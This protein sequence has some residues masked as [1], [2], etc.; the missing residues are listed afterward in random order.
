MINKN[1]LQKKNSFALFLFLF[2][3]QI[4]VKFV[5][6]IWH[7]DL[8]FQPFNHEPL[9]IHICQTMALAL[10]I[11]GMFAFGRIGRKK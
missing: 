8:N 10:S 5:S 1:I 3:Q 7:K 9:S 4:F 6:I 11:V 2:N